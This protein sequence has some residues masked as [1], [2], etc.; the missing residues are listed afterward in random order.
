MLRRFSTILLALFA[1]FASSSGAF[2]QSWSFDARKI[3]MGGSSGGGLAS[4][5]IEDERPY[6][7]IVLPFGLL[8]VFSNTDRF[9]PNKTAFD[10][11]LDA[12]Y[13]ATPWHYVIGRD[14]SSNPGEAAFIND[15]RNAHLSNVKLSKYKGFVPANDLLVEGLVE[16]SLGFTIKVHKGDR[17]GFQGI[18]IGAAPYLSTHSHT[19]IDSGLTTVLSTGVDQAN[20]SFPIAEA[21]EIQGAVA[22][23]GGYR[24]RFPWPVGVGS[25]S[26]REGLYVAVNYDYLR[27]LAYT[28]DSL[29]ITLK[30]DNSATLNNASNISVDH[31]HST[32]GSGMAIDLGVG[33]V[34]ER[35]EFTAGAKGLGNH[36]TWTGVQRETCSISDLTSGNSNFPCSNLIAV[37]DTRVEVPVDYRGS[38][39]YSADR[40]SAVTEVGHGFG[41][42]SFHGGVEWRASNTIELRAGG[43]YTV[44][45]WNPTA[46]IGLNLSRKVSIDVA[47]F[48]T[49]ANIER[50]RQMA[51][52]VSFRFNHMT[53]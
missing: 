49:N 38:V 32:G 24:G 47:T 17:G 10:P 18:Y 22:I 27:G 25:G 28:N 53:K 19:T 5:M 40:W 46:G 48:G 11:V 50:T 37:A 42:S 20:A 23:I 30:T 6:T 35:W 43:R 33:A 36:I 52:A 41:G 9:D 1:L 14:S 34:I 15:V 31:H 8:Q 45:K 26:R 21:D 29:A 2:A 44:E 13:A 51:I 39:G 12:E 7:A 3:G 16:P 4:G